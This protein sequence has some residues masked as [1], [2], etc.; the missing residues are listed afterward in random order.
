MKI[1][2]SYSKKN[3]TRAVDFISKHNSSFKGKKSYIRKRILEMIDEVACNPSSTYIGSMGCML[4]PDREFEDFETDE[5]LCRIEIYVDP[6]LMENNVY[7][8]SDFVEKEVDVNA[9]DI[10]W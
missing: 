8:D 3:L 1:K 4:I 5:N 6:S 9:E 7:F 2:V 10:N